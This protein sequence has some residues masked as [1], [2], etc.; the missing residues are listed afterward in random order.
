MSNSK[1]VQIYKLEDKKYKVNLKAINS[2]LD[3]VGNRQVAIYSI[4]GPLRDG[5]SFMLGFFLRYLICKGKGDWINYD[6]KST[7]SFKGGS[8]R[9]TVGIFMW[10]DPFIL[11][12]NGQEIALL[13]MDTQGVFDNQTTTKENAIV[14]ALSTLLSS[15]IIYNLKEKISEDVLQFLQYFAGYAKLADNEQEDETFQ[16]LLFLVRDWQKP[17]YEYGYY[18]DEH[19]IDGKNFKEDFLNAHEDQPMEVKFVHNMILSTFKDV[20]VYLMPHPGPEVARN[21]NFDTNKIDPDFLIHLKKFVPLMLNSN[22]IIEKKIGGQSLTG[23]QLKMYVE[24]WSKILKNDELP[25]AVTFFEA[26]AELQHE[27][28]KTAGVENYIRRMRDIVQSQY[29]SGVADDVFEDIHRYESKFSFPKFKF[30]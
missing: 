19:S 29:S 14:F 23:N 1:P 6:L 9:E 5:K 15:F 22:G 21:S 11:N 24:R 3:K 12:R 18:D 17:D 20:S 4:N 8:K 16:K 26:A 7:F 27:M 13:L 10:S 25:K 2:I 28:A 30:L